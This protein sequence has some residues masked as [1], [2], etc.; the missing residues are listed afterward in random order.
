M[1]TVAEMLNLSDDDLQ[2]V[3]DGFASGYPRVDVFKQLETLCGSLPQGTPERRAVSDVLRRMDDLLWRYEKSREITSSN[4]WRKLLARYPGQSIITGQR[5]E[6]GTQIYY[7]GATREAAP[8]D[9]AMR[10]ANCTI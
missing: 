6:A 5:F 10:F 8:V 4:L 1:A 9:E 2:S 3:V 7:C